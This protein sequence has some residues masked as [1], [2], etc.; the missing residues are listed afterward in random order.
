[1]S[2]AIAKKAKGSEEAKPDQLIQSK[3]GKGQMENNTHARAAM[4]VLEIFARSNNTLYSRECS[5]SDEGLQH[6]NGTNVWSWNKTNFNGQ[7]KKLNWIKALK[8]KVRY[9]STVPF[10]PTVLP[11]P[12]TRPSAST[13]SKG[14]LLFTSLMIRCIINTQR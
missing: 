14:S 9:Y 12:I 13:G 6:R 4:Q 10:D 11:S 7:I 2:T 1:M 3:I 5:P 8:Q